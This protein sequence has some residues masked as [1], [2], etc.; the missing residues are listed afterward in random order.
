[1][2]DLCLPLYGTAAAEVGARLAAAPKPIAALDVPLPT[3]RQQ[4]ADLVE[5]QRVDASVDK[6]RWLL[7]EQAHQVDPCD[8]AFADLAATHPDTCATGQDYPNWTPGRTK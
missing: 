5:R 4:V 1:M 2:T 6:L 3:L 8:T 7:A